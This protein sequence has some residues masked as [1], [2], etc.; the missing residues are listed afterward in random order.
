MLSSGRPCGS[1][2]TMLYC[3]KTTQEGSALETKTVDQKKIITG[4]SIVL[5]ILL[6]IAVALPPRV[7]DDPEKQTTAVETT[8][9][10]PTTA[11]PTVPPPEAGI[12]GPTDFQFDGDYLKMQ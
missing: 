11:E 8:T 10:P 5:A 4:L 12:Y 2:Q 3:V 1:C 7:Q 9:V 6:L